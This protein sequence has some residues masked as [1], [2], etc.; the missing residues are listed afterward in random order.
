MIGSYIFFSDAMKD[1]MDNMTLSEFMTKFS[2][3]SKSAKKSAKKP[4]LTVLRTVC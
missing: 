2:Y 1:V 4:T 3:E